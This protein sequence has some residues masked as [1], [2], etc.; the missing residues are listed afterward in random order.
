MVQEK[1][2][3][4]FMLENEDVWLYLI[5]QIDAEKGAHL[6][7]YASFISKWDVDICVVLI[8]Y[9]IVALVIV[10]PLLTDLLIG[11]VVSVYV[12]AMSKSILH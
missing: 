12:V 3:H 9:T 1:F 11:Y 6:S 10:T 8:S 2:R 4:L 7:R 5:S